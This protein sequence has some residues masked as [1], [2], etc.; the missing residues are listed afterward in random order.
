VPPNVAAAQAAGTIGAEHAR[1]IRRF[2]ADLPNAVD[3]ETRQ[4]CETD[5][6]RIASEHTPDALRKA[7]DRLM[8]LVHPDGDFSD[9]DRARRRHLILGRQEADGMSKISGLLDP[10][11]RANFE[12]VLTNWPHQ[13][14]ATPMTRAPASTGRLAKPT[15]TMTS[16][17]RP[18]ATTTRSM[19]GVK[20]RKASLEG[21][22]RGL[23]GQYPPPPNRL[24]TPALASSCRR[25]VRTWQCR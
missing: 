16:A 20:C 1:I 5:L 8:E 4:A 9:I 23:Y 17:A 14:C 21:D 2:F 7:A 25:P 10:E 18:N 24:Q 13:A 12:A 6:A 15:S 11:T 19:R 3:F 22:E